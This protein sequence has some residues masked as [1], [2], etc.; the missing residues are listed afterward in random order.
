MALANGAHRTHFIGMDITG[1]S[2]TENYFIQFLS[3]FK[4]QSNKKHEN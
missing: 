4:L 2:V 1:R 3:S